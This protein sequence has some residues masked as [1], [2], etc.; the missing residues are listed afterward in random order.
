MD[1]T[2]KSK[3]KYFE[4]IPAVPNRDWILSRLGYRKGVTELKTRDLQLIDECI[5]QGG[6]LCK[7][8]GAYMNISIIDKDMTG[9]VLDNNIS[10][11]SQSLSKLLK[12]SHS[13][14][15]M[16]STVGHEVS[17]KVFTEIENG[18]A[19]AGLIL[20]SVASQTADA[21]LDWM[22]QMLDKMLI[23]EGKKLTKHRY[24]PGFG[25]LPLCYQKDIFEALQLFRLN[26]ALTEKFM[27]IPEKSVIAIAGVED[28]GEL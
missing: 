21:A 10:L 28:K 4:N 7:P 25:D 13:V 15:L 17:K 27:L 6:Y 3:V 22:V 8:A 23:R 11:M 18:N 14:I 12:D 2:I 1:E 20:D 24:S 19:S 16:A 26:M 5:Q 9:I